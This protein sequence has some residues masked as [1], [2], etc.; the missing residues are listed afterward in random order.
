MMHRGSDGTLYVD[1]MGSILE[2]FDPD[3]GGVTFNNALNIR[4]KFLRGWKKD[5]H[6]APPANGGS[7]G[8]GAFCVH[9]GKPHAADAMF[10]ASCGK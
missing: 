8:G 10:C 9:C 4:L 5:G 6:S 2:D 3:G 1:Y 7:S